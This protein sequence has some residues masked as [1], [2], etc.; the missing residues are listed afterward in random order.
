MHFS[1]RKKNFLNLKLVQN[2]LLETAQQVREHSE[3]VCSVKTEARQRHSW[4][5]RVWTFSQEEEPHNPPKSVKLFIRAVLSLF[6]FSQ[7]STYFNTTDLP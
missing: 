3:E 1:R 7:L 4:R 6:I 5:E 2:V